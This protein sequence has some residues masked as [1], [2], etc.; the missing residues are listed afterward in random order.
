MGTAKLSFSWD[1]GIKGSK[2]SVVL[3]WK[4]EIALLLTL[5]HCYILYYVGKNAL[6]EQHS[7]T[8]NHKA[9]PQSVSLYSTKF[10]ILVRLSFKLRWM[11]KIVKMAIWVVEVTQSQLQNMLAK[12]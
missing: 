11:V 7:N 10:Q 12:E 6:D 1:S 3:V 4:A 8:M 2:C 5:E 9:R